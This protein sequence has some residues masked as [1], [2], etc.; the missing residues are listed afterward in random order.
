MLQILSKKAISKKKKTLYKYTGEYL[1][2]NLMATIAILRQIIKNGW[3]I[4]IEEILF[5]KLGEVIL[6]KLHH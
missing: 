1:G 5:L 4:A 6:M 3:T 2:D